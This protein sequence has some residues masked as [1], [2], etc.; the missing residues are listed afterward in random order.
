L[1]GRERLDAGSFMT[2]LFQ[3]LEYQIILESNFII[4]KFDE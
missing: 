1:A 2:I 3:N 4:P